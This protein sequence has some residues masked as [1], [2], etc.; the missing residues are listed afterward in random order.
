MGPLLWKKATRHRACRYERSLHIRTAPVQQNQTRTIRVQVPKYEVYTPNH[1]QDSDCRNRRLSTVVYC[2]F[3][4][5]RRFFVV[6]LAS[7]STSIT[8]VLWTLRYGTVQQNTPRQPHLLAACPMLPQEVEEARPWRNGRET[9]DSHH[10][11]KRSM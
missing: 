11:P 10:L 7:S 8:W 1:N 2:A 4:F 3:L 9:W 5:E 6:S